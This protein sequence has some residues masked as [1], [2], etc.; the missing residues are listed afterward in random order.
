ML[1]NRTNSVELVGHSGIFRLHGDYVFA[2]YLVRLRTRP[3][4]LMPDYLNEFINSPTGQRR[5]RV[6]L[7]KGVSQAN[8]SASKLKT[9]MVP[10]PS[11]QLQ[12]R[13][14]ECLNGLRERRSLIA[15]RLDSV[16]GLRGQLRAEIFGA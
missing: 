16:A 6:H 2:S 15:S 14:V 9:V 5:I 4:Q 8:I 3:D 1:F 12:Q 7:S 10:V 13:V 11:L